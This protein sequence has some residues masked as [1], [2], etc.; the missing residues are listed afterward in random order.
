[1]ISFET[2]FLLYT[3]PIEVDDPKD[4]LKL[5]KKIEVHY[6]NEL[7]PYFQSK[8]LGIF[9]NTN[10]NENA[11]FEHTKKGNTLLFKNI[12]LFP[13]L[14][15]Y[16]LTEILAL[17]LNLNVMQL[18][19]EFLNME[20]ICG[21]KSYKLKHDHIYNKYNN[22]NLNIY[23]KTTSIGYNKIIA[24]V[25]PSKLAPITFYENTFY[26]NYLQIGSYV[27]DIV[28]NTHKQKI[29]HLNIMPSITSVSLCLIYN[30]EAVSI[31]IAKL[32]NIH[33]AGNQFSKVYIQSH[34][35]D[36]NEMNEREMQYVK[37][38][39]E[40][41][42][43][44]N[45]V[46]S[47][48][49]VCSLYLGEEVSAGVILS[50]LDICENSLININFTVIDSRLNYDEIK[51]ILSKWSSTKMIKLLHDTYIEE[52]VYDINFNVSSYVPFYGDVTS[53]LILAN[54]SLKDIGEVNIL[55]NQAIPTIKFPTKT[56]IQFSM[57][58]FNNINTYYKFNYL[59]INK[60]F[61]TENLIQRSY[62]PTCHAGIN[63]TTNFV[64]VSSIHAGSYEES[65][66][67]YSMI[68]GIFS[69]LNK[70]GSESTVKEA[71]TY[72]DIQKR[73][74]K[75]NKKQLLK[76]LYSTDPM[77]FGERNV[78]NSKR[79]YSGLAQKSEQRVVPIT[80]SEYA[81][82]K[83]ESPQSVADIQ[84]QTFK[85]QR[86]YLYCPYKNTNVV[87]FH[88]IPNQ[89]CIPRCTAKLSN[90]SQL[91]F[92]IK[93]LD[94]RGIEL[95]QGAENQSITLYNPII[96]R[97]RKCKLPLE[98]N[99][100]FPN[101]ICIKLQVGLRDLDTYYR[102][103]YGKKPFVIKRDTEYEKYEIW[104]EYNKDEDYILTLF[105]ERTQED[106]FMIMHDSKPLLFSENE[107]IR[108]FFANATVKTST[109]LKF[110]DFVESITKINLDNLYALSIND[111]IK[112]LHKKCKLLVAIVNNIVFGII[113]NGKLF[114]SP[115]FYWQ[116]NKSEE[117]IQILNV[118]RGFKAKEI[119]LPDISDFNIT[120]IKE[121]YIDYKSDQIHG[122][123][124]KDVFSFTKGSDISKTYKQF[125]KI[126]FDFA[127]A[128]RSQILNTETEESKGPESGRIN[129]YIRDLEYSYLFVYLIII[130]EELQ[131]NDYNEDDELDIQQKV[132]QIT[133]RKK[134]IHNYKF[135]KEE[136]MK[137]LES[138]KFLSNETS[139]VFINETT[140]I[141]SWRKSKLEKATMTRFLDELQDVDI[142]SITMIIY[143]QLEQSLKINTSEGEKLYSKIIT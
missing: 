74:M 9:G 91:N 41:S 106:V 33:T 61:L 22:I 60:D 108:N 17:S 81:I 101:Y 54:G 85:S 86:L 134:N 131:E 77:L 98:L 51:T 114:F 62:L 36:A 14:T 87:N 59:L 37:T 122:I 6:S 128:F 83:K 8:T 112:Y 46:A 99:N 58:T 68:I 64:S 118:I 143:Q 96:S 93:S 82:I 35:I 109:Q 10:T 38:S 121:L 20:S 44:F 80:S 69:I 97:G 4:V 115:N 120:Y 102:D 130:N 65:L 136:F 16:E 94:V 48:Y 79:P 92:C 75:I 7:Q 40:A 117:F 45:G 53:S 29:S 15:V 52:C 34:K 43:P 105:A 42:N 30:G 140:K 32:F 55:T 132:S 49:E 88:S 125:P 78:G 104:T 28:K 12:C 111:I 25:L 76:I 1:M 123:N 137:F 5:G 73:A 90:K 95:T 138:N 119:Q 127:T 124:Y 63:L 13:C 24:H 129:R 113:F 26:N 50:S 103:M 139:I 56:S 31:D 126:Q 66:Y 71:N 3:F 72:K 142:Y 100:I 67:H 19:L 116:Y 110:F 135:N 70:V 107:V 18:K 27:N 133:K 57:Y 84:N 89:L 21:T 11:L 141:V 2:S 39:T 47:L 23:N